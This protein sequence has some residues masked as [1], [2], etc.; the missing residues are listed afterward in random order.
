[1]FA[2]WFGFRCY[3]YASH[4]H[5]DTSWEAIADLPLV[6]GRSRVSEALCPEWISVTN[7]QVPEEFWT[8]LDEGD[9]LADGRTW[10]VIR[11]FSVHCE[12]RLALE[13]R[14][15][16]EAS[17]PDEDPVVMMERIPSTRHL[18]SD[19]GDLPL[20]EDSVKNLV[21]DN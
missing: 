3:N 15:R 9:Q 18:S 19:G 12:E 4:H 11:Q 1:M 6:R 2:C 13:R 14:I 16:R 17:M 10:R 7:T 5:S 21:S 20:D 8:A